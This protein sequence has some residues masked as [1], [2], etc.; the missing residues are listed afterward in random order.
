MEKMN[1]KFN[2]I[3]AGVECRA[4]SALFRL[5]ARVYINK[6]MLTDCTTKDIS[7]QMHD[8]MKHI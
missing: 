8:G 3:W 1:E 7:C 2:S 4:R 6:L 5:F